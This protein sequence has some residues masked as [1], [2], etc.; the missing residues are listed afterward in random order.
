[1]RGADCMTHTNSWMTSSGEFLQQFFI[2]NK[3]DQN[4]ILIHQESLKLKHYI[5]K[6]CLLSHLILSN[7]LISE[8][9][10]SMCTDEKRM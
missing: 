9:P 6:G 8:T 10:I 2:I 5:I 1:M 7:S 3:N 4:V